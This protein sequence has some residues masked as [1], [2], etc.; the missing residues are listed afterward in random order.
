MI[1]RVSLILV[2]LLTSCKFGQ[3]SF[4]DTSKIENW[5]SSNIPTNWNSVYKHDKDGNSYYI[6][7]TGWYVFIENNEVKVRPYPVKGFFANLKVLFNID[8]GDLAILSGIKVKEGFLVGF[9]RGEFIGELRWYSNKR[10]IKKKYVGY[11]IIQ[12]IKRD[13][14]VYAMEGLYH[15]ASSYGSIINLNFKDNKYVP[16]KYLK[17]PDAPMAIALDTNKNFLV[18]TSKSILTVNQ[19]KTIQIILDDCFW[20][21]GLSPNSIVINNDIIYAGMREGVFKYNLKTKKQE[22]LL[23]D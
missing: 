2:S 14:E 6:P 18:I 3:C 15:M 16:R 4:R 22:W 1:F 20:K 9:N 11:D 23:P 12:F 19:D 10:K 13:S 21:F 5:K 7:S 8:K 17:L